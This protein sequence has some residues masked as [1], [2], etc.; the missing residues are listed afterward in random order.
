MLAGQDWFQEAAVPC[1]EIK[2]ELI[3]AGMVHVLEPENYNR[4]IVAPVAA[5]LLPLMYV[6]PET[7][8]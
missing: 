3:Q 2:T 5:A 8:R 4:Q 6:A 7:F 1:F